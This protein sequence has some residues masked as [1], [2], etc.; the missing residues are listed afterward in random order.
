MTTPPP[1]V[2]ATFELKET[3]VPLV[4]TKLEPPP[5]PPQPLPPPAD[6]PPPPPKTPPPP[7]PP[8]QPSWPPTPP[9]NVVP[10]PPL[11]EGLGNNDP[12]PPIPP[13]PPADCVAPCPPPPNV[14]A[15]LCPAVPLAPLGP[16]PAPP[17]PSSLSV[18]FPPP[19]A[20]MIALD[21]PQVAVAAQAP[22]RTSVAPPPPPAQPLPPLPPPFVPP[23]G[24]SGVAQPPPL[25]PTSNR[26][27]C[28]D[29]NTNEPIASPP[30][31][32][33]PPTRSR[34]IPGQATGRRERAALI[35]GGSPSITRV[36]PNRRRPHV[37]IGS[38][39][40]VSRGPLPRQIDPSSVAVGAN[41]VWI[42]RVT[43]A[44]RS[45]AEGLPRPSR[46]AL[47]RRPRHLQ[48]AAGS[49]A[50]GWAGVSVGGARL[51]WT[52]ASCKRAGFSRIWQ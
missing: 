2:P 23:F 27:A 8:L 47:R 50:I 13:G 1:S 40:T 17:W 28:P 43:R 11:G 37:A 6:P 42:T 3:F 14:P 31:A 41:G 48:R 35:D 36:I 18:A 22:T 33:M 46:R 19:P 16:P 45:R 10:S 25:P 52:P 7:P 5:P 38:T 34:A 12:T 44:A 15:P 4:L 20:T 21:V 24:A 51:R 49:L 32:P 30:K 29:V 26:R 9:C 39:K